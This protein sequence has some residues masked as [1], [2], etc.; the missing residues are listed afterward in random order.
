MRLP[1]VRRQDGEKMPFDIRSYRAI[2]YDDSIGGKKTVETN[3][4]QHINAILCDS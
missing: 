2:F 4:R 3:L 1:W